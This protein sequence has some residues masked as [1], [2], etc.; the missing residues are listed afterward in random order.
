MI[1]A[2]ID[3]YTKADI[4]TLSGKLLRSSR[5]QQHHFTAMG[6]LQAQPLWLSF[7]AQYGVSELVSQAHSKGAERET[8]QLVLQPKKLK[9]PVHLTFVIKHN[10]TFIKTI[11][12]IVD[13]LSLANNEY[14]NTTLN[15]NSV[16][17]KLPKSDPIIVSDLDNQLHPTTFHATPSAICELPSHIARTLD[18]WWQIWQTN[19]LAHFNSLYTPSATA[20]LAGN[21]EP[22]P[23][24][25]LL[26]CHLNFT[27]SLSRRYAQLETVEYDSAKNQATVCWTLDGSFNAKNVRVR[28]Q[29]IT[30]ITINDKLITDEVMQFDT[31]ALSQQFAL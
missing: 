14:V 28:Q 25:A 30:V 18:N 3:L 29:I 2:I 6:A 1:N 24:S 10:G 22:Q 13:T 20:I 7:L 27:Q 8:L 9:S 19:N 21:T 16:I 17:P 23:I 12:C 31:L 11:K 26:D 15:N 4:E 5:W